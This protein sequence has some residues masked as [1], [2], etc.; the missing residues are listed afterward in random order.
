MIGFGPA[1]G[2]LWQKPGCCRPPRNL[3]RV[4]ITGQTDRR[5][6]RYRGIVIAD[7]RTAEFGPTL[8]V[9]IGRGIVNRLRV[10][11]RDA[12]D[13]NAPGEIRDHIRRQAGATRISTDRSCRAVA[14][15]IIGTDGPETY[16]PHFTFDGYRYARIRLTG[17]Q[18][19]SSRSRSPRCHISPER[20][21]WPGPAPPYAAAASRRPNPIAMAVTKPPVSS[22]PDG[23]KPTAAAAPAASPRHGG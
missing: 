2:P 10:V 23:V 14:N 15:D 5:Q 13:G 12:D 11:V 16:A 8:V 19:R 20:H 6:G 22:P 4:V 1:L 9:E 18:A 7:H 21:L 3:A 17:G